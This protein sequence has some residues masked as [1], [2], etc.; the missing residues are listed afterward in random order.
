M[1]QTKIVRLKDGCDVL[2]NVELV[3]GEYVLNYPMIVD[4]IYRKN[5][6][7]EL[8]LTNW[9]PLQLIEGHSVTIPVNQVVCHMQPNAHLTEYYKNLVDKV[10]TFSESEEELVSKEHVE[11]LASALE[12]LETYK[13]IIIH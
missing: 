8:Q 5:V 7:P 2:A 3:K 4:L 6:A 11:Q 9:L 1:E 10:S 12:E 13:G